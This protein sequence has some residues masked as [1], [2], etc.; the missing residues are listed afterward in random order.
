MAF[1][2][3]EP[4]GEQAAFW[5]AGMLAS[6]IANVYRAKGKKAFKPEHFMPKEPKE[7]E[8]EDWQVSLK[9][10]QFYVGGQMKKGTS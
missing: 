2:Q 7:S 1:A 10:M 3:L 8:D 4:F 6:V 9:R 5:R